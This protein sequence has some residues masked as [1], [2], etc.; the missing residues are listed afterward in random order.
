MNN[1]RITAS[2]VHISDASRILKKKIMKAFL[3]FIIAC[4]AIE[5]QCVSAIEVYEFRIK[6]YYKN[7]Y[8]VYFVDY[9]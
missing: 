2:V 4:L 7:Q 6:F 1:I 3:I 9:K 8:F 5:C